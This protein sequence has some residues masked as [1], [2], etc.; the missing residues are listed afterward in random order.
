[1]LG[2]YE[3]LDMKKLENFI[4]VSPVLKFVEIL[5]TRL[6]E[7]L[8]PESKL[9]QAEYIEI[10]QNDLTLPAVL[11]HFQ[12]RRASLEC[13]RCDNSELSKFV[14]AW[15]SGE[16]CQKLEF[17]KVERLPGNDQVFAQILHAIGAKYIDAAKQPPTHS[18]PRFSSR[19]IVLDNERAMTP[20]TSHT[21]VVRESDNRVA[22]V[23][24]QEKKFYFGVWDK[25]EEEF[26]RMVE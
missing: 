24:I 7:P 21:Y 15:K 14:N 26:L 12:G 8:S 1:M 13:I 2:L 16:A 3:P 17:L 25:T 18:L 4:S 19:F 22:S 9:Y 23:L 10:I 11:R 6:T 20:I 5:A